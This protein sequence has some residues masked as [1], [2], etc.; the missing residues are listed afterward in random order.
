MTE[1]EMAKKSSNRCEGCDRK[2]TAKQRKIAK[3][4]SADKVLCGRCSGKGKFP[5]Y[6]PSAF[7]AVKKRFAETLRKLRK[8]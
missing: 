1:I 2:L 3:A 4:L 6:T 8:E 5:Y 7:D